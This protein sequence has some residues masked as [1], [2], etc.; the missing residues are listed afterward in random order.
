MLANVSENGHYELT[1]ER[2]ALLNTIRYAEG[3]WK[4]G[5]DKGYK[6]LYGGGEFKDLSRHPD[7]VVVKRYASAAAGDDEMAHTFSIS[8]ARSARRHA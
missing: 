8:A 5:E 3:T 7:R 1:P 4:N 6:V 2:R